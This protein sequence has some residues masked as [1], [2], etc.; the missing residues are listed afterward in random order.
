MKEKIKHTI[1][2]VWNIIKKHKI[3]SI[4]LGIILLLI[5]FLIFKPK[6]EP[7][8]DVVTIEPTTV[9]Q[10][11][12]VTGR[13][14]A[15]QALELALQSGGKVTTVR[16]AIGD[17][18]QAGQLLLQVNT[19]DLSVRL[20]RA[21]AALERARLE[22]RKDEPK[23]TAEDT[24]TQLKEDAFTATADAFL[25]LPSVITGIDT[26]FSS[27]YIH[28]N[29]VTSKYG[30]TARTLLDAARDDFKRAEAAHK[31][32][33][34]QYRS[35]SR[36]DSLEKITPV[37]DETIEV[38]KQVSDTLKRVKSTIDY[39]ESRE[40][41]RSQ[42]DIDKA[43]VDQ[44]TGKIN[45]HLSELIRARN[46]TKNAQ[47]GIDDAQYDR[48]S[49]GLS[50]RQAELDVQDIRVQISERTIYAPISGVITDVQAKVGETVSAG[51]PLVSLISDTAYQVTAN[52]PESDMA[53]LEAGAD[54]AI[55]LDAY[56]DDVLFPAKVVTV[57]P[58]GRLVDGVATYKTTFQFVGS[59]DRIKAGMTADIVVSGEKREGVFAVPQRSVITKDGVRYVQLLVNGEV[60]EKEVTLGLRGTNGLV[61]VVEGISEGDV[62]VVFT[63][64]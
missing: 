17:R 20:A 12:S 55:T 3:K 23:T 37:M 38:L 13:V 63:A 16:G 42:I 19:S 33:S 52:I 5:C 15:A 35:I 30:T 57:S 14:E 54:A 56:S 53:K 34:V 39:I 24:F 21:Q 40:G 10:E 44:M 1:K 27:D 26:I 50:V 49:L 43:A 36:G 60:V 22:Q 28:I 64:K 61:E 11:V 58:A 59:D 2:K 51:M 48:T 7:A 62:V 18:V 9:L 46:N 32:V 45:A 41:K 6:A 8:R 47:F 25:D 31:R 4:V 29:T